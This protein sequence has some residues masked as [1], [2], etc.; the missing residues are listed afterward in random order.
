MSYVQLFQ[1][2]LMMQVIFVLNKSKILCFFAVMRFNG[3][4]EKTN[5]FDCFA[6]DF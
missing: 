2:I 5:E 6:K 3:K 1:T 4:I